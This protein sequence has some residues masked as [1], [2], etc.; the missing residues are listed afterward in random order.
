MFLELPRDLLVLIKEFLEN[1]EIINLLCLSKNSLKTLGSNHLFTSIRVNYN[2]DLFKNYKRYI[3]HHKSIKKV[4]LYGIKDPHIFWQFE[5]P[6]LSLIECSTSND[7][8]ISFSKKIKKINVKHNSF[9][10]ISVV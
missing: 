2:D 3:D 7:R 4:T 8:E 10:L 9:K 1:K 5:S 6:E